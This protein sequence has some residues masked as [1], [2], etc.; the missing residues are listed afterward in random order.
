MMVGV[1]LSLERSL[2]SSKSL[3]VHGKPPSLNETPW[4]CVNT[5]QIKEENV[6]VVSRVSLW[7]RR[8]EESSGET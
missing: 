4:S 6:L 5:S 2:R 7:P 1:P 8:P 3:K